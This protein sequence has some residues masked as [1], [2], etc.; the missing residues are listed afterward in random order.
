MGSYQV[1]SSGVRVVSRCEAVGEKKGKPSS[2]RFR[3]Q[4]VVWK[5]HSVFQAK[6]EG[7]GSV[8][9]RRA[10]FCPF[11]VD[12][13]GEHSSLCN[14]KST[15]KS[16]TLS[17]PEHGP[18]RRGRPAGYWPTVDRVSRTTFSVGPFPR[19]EATLNLGRWL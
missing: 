13:Q 4:R 9:T 16:I 3:H 6:P 11:P 14:A 2:R 8:L 15:R 19:V 18:R 1:R 12:P 10:G 17:M 7:V 5:T